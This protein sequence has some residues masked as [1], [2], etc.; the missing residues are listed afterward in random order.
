MRNLPLCLGASMLTVLVAA[1]CADNAAG[2]EPAGAPRVA[3]A[4]G[5]AEI[6]EFDPATFDDPQPNRFFPL[7]PGWVSVYRNETEDGAERITDVVTH[8]TKVI[9]GIATTVIHDTVELE[10]CGVIEDTYD[11]YAADNDGNVWYF[12]EIATDY[13]CDGQVESTAGSWEAGVDGAEPGIIMLAD[14][15]VGQAYD[16]EYAPGV[17]EDF[18]E[19][20]SL[21]RTIRLSRLRRNVGDCLETLDSSHLAPDLVEHKFYAPGLG[22]V[23]EVSPDADERVELVSHDRISPSE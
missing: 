10:G 21:D 6:P 16:Q 5:S 19:V 2:P 7:E 15:R 13:D 14:P 23:L 9:L 3:V 4:P 18:A 11:W 8:D 20:V 12:G 17:A 1:G 22:M